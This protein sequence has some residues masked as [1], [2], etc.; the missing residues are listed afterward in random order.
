VFYR[1]AG[2]SEENEPPDADPRAGAAGDG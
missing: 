2:L 1:Y